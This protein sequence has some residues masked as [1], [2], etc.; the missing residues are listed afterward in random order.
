MPAA[1]FTNTLVTL[2]VN[3]AVPLTEENIK[4]NV[5]FADSNGDTANS[6]GQGGTVTNYLTDIV[7][8]GNITWVGAVQD[9]RTYPNFY[10]IIQ[11]ITIGG[12]G[13]QN[14]ININLEPT[15]NGN[16]HVNGRV[17]GNPSATPF[18][19]TIFFRVGRVHSDGT[20]NWNDFNIDPRLRIIN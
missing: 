4:E 8:N 19:Y 20:R 12:T 2:Y 17:T 16:T 6:H 10:V 13:N 7:K 18:E 1:P 11:N 15:P 3:T 14:K 9:I 5:W